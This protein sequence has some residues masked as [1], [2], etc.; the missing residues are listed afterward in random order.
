M[1]VED[2]MLACARKSMISAGYCF[3][4]SQDKMG[5]SNARI[6]QPFEPEEDMTI[7]FGTSPKSRKVHEIKTNPNVTLAYYDPEE[8]AYVTLIGKAKV[9]K[10]IHNHWDRWHETW[11]RYFPEGPE[12]EDYVLLE[13]LPS[14]IEILSFTEGAIHQSFHLRPDVLLRLENEWVMAEVEDEKEQISAEE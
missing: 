2:K 4:I 3:F 5:R 13:F 14:R 8:I 6:M 10:N 12:S 9:E 11:K 7:F 1:R